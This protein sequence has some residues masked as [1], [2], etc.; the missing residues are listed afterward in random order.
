MSDKYKISLECNEQALAKIIAAGLKSGATVTNMEAVA[1][2]QPKPLV[3]RPS[4]TLAAEPQ[5]VAIQPRPRTKIRSPKMVSGWDVYQTMISEFHPHSSFKSRDLKKACLD[6]G[7]EVSGNS[8][9]A[10]IHRFLHA[11]LIKRTGG[12]HKGGYTY[13]VG[14]IVT[15][16]EFG[17]RR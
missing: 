17:S 2:E 14:R 9:A 1:S 13:E 4:L 3:T 5:R 10:H 15:P 12:T 8:A 7:F 16:T 11:G 6:A